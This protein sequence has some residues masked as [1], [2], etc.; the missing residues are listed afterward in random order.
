MA[1]ATFG[2]LVW[3]DPVSSPDVSAT[4]AAMDSCFSALQ[5]LFSLSVIVWMCTC[6]V[7][8]RF[9]AQVQ[10]LRVKAEQV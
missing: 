6:S 5:A 9:R 2:T 1:R 3:A 10:G 7:T 8:L 4:K